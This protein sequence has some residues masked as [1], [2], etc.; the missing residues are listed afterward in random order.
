MAKTAKRKRKPTSATAKRGRAV[1]P[2]PP[3]WMPEAEALARADSFEALLPHLR[4]GRILARCNGIYLPSGQAASGP[5]DIRPE[6]WAEARIDPATARVILTTP[7]LR[8]VSPGSPPSPPKTRE[9][10]AIGIEFERAA[11]DALW[12]V[13]PKPP[14][15]PAGTKPSVAWA[16]V[17]PHFDKLVDREG[18]F[19][20]LGSARDSVKLFLDEKKLGQ[21][22]DR[23]IERWINK[24]RPHWVRGA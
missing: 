17:Q 2:P 13:K 11:V 18:P 24:H 22:D 7:G 16:K 4:E 20:S 15:R 1:D 19:P 21:L 14:R 5:R 9:V 12:P 10:F 3:A 23:T 6:W 8:V